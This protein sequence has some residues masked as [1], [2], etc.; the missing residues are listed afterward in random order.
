LI[1][2]YNAADLVVVWYRDMKAPITIPPRYGQAN[3]PTS[4]L[5]KGERRK[6]KRGPPFGLLVSN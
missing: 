2:L 4:E 1:G 5:I 6:N 3:A